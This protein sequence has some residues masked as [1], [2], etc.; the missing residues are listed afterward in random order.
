MS[1]VSANLPI[2]HGGPVD[3]PFEPF[4][5]STLDGSIVDRFE[6][7]ARR[8]PERLAV[9]DSHRNLTYAE[10]AVL[11][12]RIANATAVAA[13]DRPGPVAIL[14]AS[15][16]FFPAA[17][18]GVLA[19]GRGYVPLDPNVP[20]ARNQLMAT[21][22]GV[23]AVLSAGAEAIAMRA[24]MRSEI[25]LIDIHALDNSDRPCRRPGP[26]DLAYIVH[27]SGSTGTPRGV[28]QDHRN[29]L[30]HIMLQSHMMHLN[31][32]DRL[33]LARSPAAIGATGDVLFALRTGPSPRVRRPCRR[34]PH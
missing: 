16:A 13:A 5:P 2:D 17:L 6:H 28:Y 8:F 9:S 19:A 1:G 14:L 15:D 18:L 33:T 24:A 30:R 29:V 11:V 4:P 21:Q 27:T 32:E 10:L 22:S 20:I 3:R 34:R 12:E 25:A 31:C 23:A 7:M 26:R